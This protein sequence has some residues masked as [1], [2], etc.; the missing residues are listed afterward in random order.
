MSKLSNVGYLNNNLDRN[1]PIKEGQDRQG[2][3]IVLPN[4]FLVD[5]QVIG[6]AR[7]DRY[8][9][10]E[11]TTNSPNILVTIANFGG[12]P[13][14]QFTINSTSHTRHKEYT[15]TT[16]YTDE[17]YGRIVVGNIDKIF[18]G[19]GNFGGSSFGMF[20]TEL[21]PTVMVTTDSPNRVTSIS[22]EG[23]PDLLK[24]DVEFE[25]ESST[26]L[27][28]VQNENDNK[29]ILQNITPV[30]DPEDCDCPPNYPDLSTI[31]GQPP[32][33]N[34]N[35]NF[36]GTGIITVTTEGNTVCINSTIDPNQICDIGT[37]IPG[38]PGPPGPA[39][40]PGP[41][42]PCV[43]P[44]PTYVDVCYDID[45][46]PGECKAD[47]VNVLIC[48]FPFTPFHFN[49]LA[50][51][52]EIHYPTL[53][54]GE[55]LDESK[56]FKELVDCVDLLKDGYDRGC[57]PI[58]IQPSGGGQFVE[59]CTADDLEILSGFDSEFKIE[60]DGASYFADLP[61]Y[62]FGDLIC[63]SMKFKELQDGKFQELD[64]A[65]L[66]TG[67]EVEVDWTGIVGT[68]SWDPTAAG[69]CACDMNDLGDVDAAAP[70][71]GEALIFNNISGNWENQALPGGGDLLAANNLSDVAS[72]PTAR[73]N[74]GLGSI[75]TQ[76]ASSVTITGGSITGITD[77]SVADGGTGASDAPTARTNLGL[78]SIATQDAS[79]VTITGGSVTGIT[80]LTVADGGTGASTASAARSN[81]GA[82]PILGT[83]SQISGA[84]TFT[85]ASEVNLSYR[86]DTSTGPYT[87]TF[88]GSGVLTDGDE[89]TFVNNIS[90]GG[91]VTLAAGAGTSIVGGFT[92]EI[93]DFVGSSQSYR[94]SATDT[95]W[96]QIAAL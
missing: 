86:V 67:K 13:V 62:R 87:I 15:P 26:G 3:S 23:D 10:S 38:P 46:E 71:N 57:P 6:A 42:T 47:D 82:A 45:L 29:V 33:C 2:D 93:G 60:C 50:G 54:L 66:P 58:C 35:F 64:G 19:L 30:T 90:G 49:N 8:F 21:E 16:T 7:G 28:F 17:I 52:H 34:G 72:A 88:P 63:N 31:N 1:Y 95:T 27:V 77:L 70:A 44:P 81:L 18:T 51:D 85:L 92:P 20:S 61:T 24:G 69:G 75:A 84:T 89:L 78:G 32:S 11:I 76:D 22:V 91:A 59:D 41:I 74:L 25:A 4:D 43:C 80:D 36:K 9:V 83:F 53:T 73:T 5:A 14:L 55:L 48:N 79:S 56:R 37:G 94:Y 40:P 39:G 68:Y 96:Y 65:G 12:N